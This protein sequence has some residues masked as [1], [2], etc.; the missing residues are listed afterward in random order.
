MR[1]LSSQ[2]CMY[3]QGSGYER[4]LY[5]SILVGG[6]FASVFS[7]AGAAVGIACYLGSASSGVA[8]F[9]TVFYSVN[10]YAVVTFPLAIFA[11]I[12]MGGTL[13]ALAGMSLYYSGL[14]S[15]P[16]QF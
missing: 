1:S 7:V 5:D 13:G 11:G 3:V 12:G 9:S 15:K 16:E 8:S 6:V 4:N 14:V 10:G 2:E